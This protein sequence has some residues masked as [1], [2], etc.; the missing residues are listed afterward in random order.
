MLVQ[1]YPDMVAH[2]GENIW[3]ATVRGRYMVCGSIVG[4]IY[5]RPPQYEWYAMPSTTNCNNTSDPTLLLQAYPAGIATSG[6]A[7]DSL[8]CDRCTP[9]GASPRTQY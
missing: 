8:G 7:G 5:C 9:G 1:E 4:S 6:M 2:N 3:F